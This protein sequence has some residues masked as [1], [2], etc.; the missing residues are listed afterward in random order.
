MGQEVN[1]NSLFIKRNAH[2]MDAQRVGSFQ[3][4]RA[5]FISLADLKKNKQTV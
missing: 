4:I 3:T 5:Y 1:R 2:T